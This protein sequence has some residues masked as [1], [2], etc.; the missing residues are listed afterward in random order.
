VWSKPE[1]EPDHPGGWKLVEE[2]F[3]RTGRIWHLHVGGEL[4]RT[5]GEHPFYVLGKGWLEARLLQPGDLLCTRDGRTVAVEECYDTGEYE[6]VYNC[7]VA[8]W[9]TYFVGDEGWAFDVWAHNARCSIADVQL[10]APSLKPG[11]ARY[12]AGLFNK[13]HYLTAYA[14]L[15]KKGI[16]TTS[17]AMMALRDKL[18]R[19][20]GVPTTWTI[21]QSKK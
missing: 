7:R 5:T 19:P 10:A 18:L 13:G 6:T 11:Q 12:V 16:N 9:H 3:V 2:L 8:E 4:I 1:D 17:P 21:K 20:A 15:N 14:Y